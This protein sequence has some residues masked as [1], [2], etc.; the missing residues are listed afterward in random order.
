MKKII[1]FLLIC[2]LLL[3]TTACSGQTSATDVSIGDLIEKS[4]EVHEFYYEVAF[5]NEPIN[6]L[7][8]TWVKNDNARAETLLMEGNVLLSTRGAIYQE[9]SGIVEQYAIKHNQP[10]NNAVI[11]DSMG[12]GTFEGIREQTFL[13][14]IDDIDPSV[15]KIIKTERINDYDCAVI[16]N[17][18]AENHKKIWISTEWGVPLKV[19]TG[20][21]TLIYENI[22]VGPGTITDKD[23]IKPEN[24]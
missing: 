1:P 17:G 7:Q 16:D 5:G 19:E 22:K 21:T 11:G 6:L 12:T 4:H 14:E 18:E 15:A 8:K 10:N 13:R 3:T 23:L 24:I 9:D 20:D 2:I